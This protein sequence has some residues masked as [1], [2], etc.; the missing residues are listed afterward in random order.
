MYLICSFKLISMEINKELDKINWL[1]VLPGD[2]ETPKGMKVSVQKNSANVKFNGQT[3]VL[4]TSAQKT[5]GSIWFEAGKNDFLN[6]RFCTALKVENSG[7]REVSFSL[8]RY[9]CD[10]L[11]T[12]CSSL[13]SKVPPVINSNSNAG[14]TLSFPSLDV[15]TSDTTN[16]ICFN[17]GGGCL[18]GKSLKLADSIHGN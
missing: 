15:P 10:D 12:L 8:P 1:A 5:A 2:W 4:K 3:T 16:V 17:C 13:I 7:K 9:F 6:G 14:T 11:L 18:Y